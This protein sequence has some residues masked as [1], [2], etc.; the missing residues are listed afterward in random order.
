V[1]YGEFDTNLGPFVD[2][3]TTWD[4]ERWVVGLNV[5]VTNEILLRAE[6]AFNSEDTGGSPGS[7]D[8][9]ELV[10]ELRLLF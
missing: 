3:P 2:L 7:V 8:N 10:I 6:Y 5:E 9:D 4:R 1:R